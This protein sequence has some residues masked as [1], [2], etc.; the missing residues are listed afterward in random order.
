MAEEDWDVVLDVNLKGVFLC[1]QAAAK[2]MVERRYGKII[3]IASITGQSTGFVPG[4]SNYAA[5]KAGII[6]LTRVCAQELGPYGINV[7]AIAP[8]LIITDILYTNKTQEEVDR[9]V[10]EREKLAVLGRAGRTQDIANLALFLASDDSSFITGQ[11]IAS[12]GG[13]ARIIYKPCQK[14]PGF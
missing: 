13:R 7:N 6:Q 5:S 9:W 3:N 10:E 14:T 8:G 11:V 4:Q 12:D 1:T 2:Y